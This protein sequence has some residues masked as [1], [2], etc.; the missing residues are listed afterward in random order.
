[1]STQGPN[2]QHPG[3]NVHHDGSSAGSG[4]RHAT[5]KRKGGRRRGERELARAAKDR[6]RDAQYKLRNNPPKPGDFWICEFCEYERI[7][8][9]PPMALIRQYE[10]KD[11]KLRRQEQERKRLLEKA[12]AKSRKAKK[13]GKAAGKNSGTTQSHSHQGVHPDDCHGPSTTTDEEDEEEYVNGVDHE[14][15]HYI[16][17]DPPMILSD[18]PDVDPDHDDLRHRHPPG[19]QCSDSLPIPSM[20]HGA[21]VPPGSA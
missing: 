14:D 20:H 15:G 7:F 5:P 19:C 21:V 17:D 1:M 2:D 9:E 10:I 3:G 16:D 6:R 11:Q 8:G 13:S 18:D 12:K 4:D